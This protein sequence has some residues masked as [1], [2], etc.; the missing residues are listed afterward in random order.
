[1][2]NLIKRIAHSFA[3]TTGLDYKDLYQEATLAYLEAMRTY[4]PERGAPSTHLW[5]CVSNHLKNYIKNQP[6]IESIPIEEIEQGTDVAPFW[7]KLSKDALGIASVVLAYPLP[8][9]ELGKSGSPKKIKEIMTEKG[10]G[11]KKIQRGISELQTIFS[12]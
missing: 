3:N 12:Q 2:E 11:K 1:M 6:Q 10:W 7:E 4:D 9:L 5:H 8:F